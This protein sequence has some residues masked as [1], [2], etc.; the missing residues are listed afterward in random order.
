M[1]AALLAL[2]VACAVPPALP[3]AGECVPPGKTQGE[4]CAAT[5]ECAAGLTCI[6]RI[7]M[8]WE[9]CETH[10]TE[11]CEFPDCIEGSRPDTIGGEWYHD[12]CPATAEWPAFT[13]ATRGRPECL[14]QWVSQ[15]VG[16][17]DIRAGQFG[18]DSLWDCNEWRR[19][20]ADRWP[21]RW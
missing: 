2:L 9:A 7:G 1:R 11:G 20:P 16:T 8:C 14:T 21:R 12:E 19:V 17:K 15:E 3:D 10:V 5:A 18:G 4:T 13:I 6:Q